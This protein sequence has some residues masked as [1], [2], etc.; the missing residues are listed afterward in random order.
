M[1][2]IDR[3]VCDYEGFAYR[4]EFWG[5]GRDY[6]DGVER[7]ALRR[8]LPPVGRR[9]IDIGCRTVACGLVAAKSAGIR[10]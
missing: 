10:R 7:A 2:Q 6:E 8:L 4:T 5:R 3:P 9:L 1:A